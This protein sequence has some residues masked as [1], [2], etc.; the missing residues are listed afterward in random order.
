[1]GIEDASRKCS[2]HV[3]NVVTTR[4]SIEIVV[5]DD[6]NEEQPEDEDDPLTTECFDH[7]FETDTDADEETLH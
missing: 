6:D 1:M 3:K 5:V 4:G 2:L 7:A